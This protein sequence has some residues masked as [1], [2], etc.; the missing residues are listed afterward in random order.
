M[1]LKVTIMVHHSVAVV[2]IEDV[3]V[4]VEVMISMTKKVTMDFEVSAVVVD[5]DVAGAVVL[6][7]NEE[8]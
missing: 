1:P 2:F 7:S 5:V 4:M 6:A 8:D 3:V